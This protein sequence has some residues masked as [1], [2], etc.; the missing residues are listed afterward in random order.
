MNQSGNAVFTTFAFDT[1]FLWDAKA[2]KVAAVALSGMPA[3]NGMTFGQ[4]GGGKPAINNSNEIAFVAQVKDTTGRVLGFGVFFRGRDGDLVPVALPGQALPD[5]SQ[6]T[7]A[8]SPILNDAGLI[9]FLAGR[10]GQ[11]GAS[12]YLWEKGAL[13]PIAE[14]GM[15]AP[16]DGTIVDVLNAWVN[17]RNRN[18][19]LAARVKTATQRAISLYL[20]TEGKLIPVLT[21]G[22]EMPGGGRL[23]GLRALFDTFLSIS[24]PNDLGQQAVLVDLTEDGR[25]RTGACLLDAEGKL[26][27]ILKSGTVTDLGEI[28]QVLGRTSIGAGLHNKGQVALTLRIAGMPSMIAL[29]TTAAQ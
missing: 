13:M 25:N 23:K 20:F 10:K 18:V 19:L 9:S 12:A 27:L 22:Q 26:S 2:Q 21:P 16:G 3:V 7:E 8:S 6:I 14:V 11:D 4:T 29:L 5:G 15:A 17:N 28:A 24:F 1:T